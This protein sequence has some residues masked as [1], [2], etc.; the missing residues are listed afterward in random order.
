MNL[1]TLAIKTYETTLPY[2]KQ[3]IE[4]RPYVVR[5]ERALLL[6]S[7]DGKEK[8]MIRATINLVNACVQTE[9]IDAEK[10]SSVDLEWL[11]IHIR[12]KSVGE[13]VN[14]VQKC[15]EEECSQEF[16]IRFNIENISMRTTEGFNT[17][18]KT[19]MGDG[20]TLVIDFE[21]P[22]VNTYNK[23]L[24]IENEIQQSFF[25]IEACIQ[26][27][28]YDGNTHVRGQ[29]F[30]QADVSAFFD[31]LPAQHL[32]EIYV[33]VF[34]KAPKLIHE[35]NTTCPHCNKDLSFSVEGLPN[36]FG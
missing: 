16:E 35:F 28:T 12:S 17:T 20:Q 22:T 24:E 5:E 3:K 11:F 25:L 8:D 4:F 18:Y 26:K 19:D 31:Q 2:S 15:S 1:P 34:E 10:L 14:F 23:S 27:I 9:N 33:Q 30:E 32:S 21:L 36:F 13:E 6:A 7:Q 29:D